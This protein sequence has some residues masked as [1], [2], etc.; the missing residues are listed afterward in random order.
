[1]KF[2]VNIKMQLVFSDYLCFSYDYGFIER[3]IVYVYIYVL[4]EL[5]KCSNIQKL[6]FHVHTFVN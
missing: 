1:M 2:Q 6:E 4:D 5:F 3:N